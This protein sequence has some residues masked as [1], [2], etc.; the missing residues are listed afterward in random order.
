MNSDR[1][2]R[3][4][5]RYRWVE[6]VGPVLFILQSKVFILLSDFFWASRIVH[7]RCYLASHVPCC[8]C[9]WRNTE[10]LEPLIGFGLVLRF[11]ICAILKLTTQILFY[12]VRYSCYFST[13][14][15]CKIILA[16]IGL[17]PWNCTLFEVAYHIN[18]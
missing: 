9:T 17:N 3:L 8:T 18:L 6:R 16:L 2:Y 15:L 11:E 14:T 12:S 5:R 4:P 7:G 1:V 10:V 13:Y